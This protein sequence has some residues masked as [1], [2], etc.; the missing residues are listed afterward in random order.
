MKVIFLDIDGVLNVEVFINAFWMICKIGKLSRPEAKQLFKVEMRDKYGNLFCPTTINA[1]KY[2]IEETGAKIVISSTWRAS[3][4]K[5]MQE[6]WK[7]RELPG[8]II[9]ITPFSESR[10]RGYEIEEWLKHNPV[11]NYVI[12]DDDRDMLPEQQDSFVKTDPIYGLT[13]SKALDCIKILN[14]GDKDSNG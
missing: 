7:H 11:D 2:L 5:I 10:E 14:N 9:D 12:I 8:E 3:G 13:L 6:M 4:L 1:L